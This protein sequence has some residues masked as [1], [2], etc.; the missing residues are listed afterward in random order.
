MRIG[1]I[2]IRKAVSDFLVENGITLR[3]LLDSMDEDPRSLKESLRAR[4]DTDE[5]KIDI[6]EERLTASQLNYLIFVLHTFYI[7]NAGG[8]YKGLLLIPPR[9]LVIRGD[10][11]TFQGLKLLAKSLGLPNIE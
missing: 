2:D 8:F 7:I 1:Y 3:D 6:I 11:A 10:K 9:E 5:R 4:V